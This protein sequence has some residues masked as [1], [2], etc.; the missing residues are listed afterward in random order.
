MIMSGLWSLMHFSKPRCA[1]NDCMPLRRNLVGK[2]AEV[3]Y[4]AY[5]KAGRRCMYRYCRTI[6]LKGQ[7]P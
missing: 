7:G 5:H 2:K 3:L 6:L 4:I 1:R